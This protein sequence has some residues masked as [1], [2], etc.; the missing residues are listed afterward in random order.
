[1]NSWLSLLLHSLPAPPCFPR[2]PPNAKT[3][4]GTLLRFLRYQAGAYSSQ[5]YFAFATLPERM[6]AVQTRTVLWTPSTMA[7]TWRKLGFHRRL[8][9]LWAWLI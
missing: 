3:Y 5:R 6:Q 4:F 9:T 7:W 2:H 1:M 8:V